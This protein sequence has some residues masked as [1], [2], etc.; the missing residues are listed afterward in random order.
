MNTDNTVHI[1]NTG[2]APVIVER[3]DNDREKNILIL[4]HHAQQLEILKGHAYGTY[5]ALEQQ[6]QD[7]YDRLEDLQGLTGSEVA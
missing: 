3:K 7:T 5:A 2:Y 4:Q 1:L 6:L